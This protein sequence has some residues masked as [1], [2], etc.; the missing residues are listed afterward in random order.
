MYGA[1]VAERFQRERYVKWR[2]DP[3]SIYCIFILLGSVYLAIFFSVY[4]YLQRV[5]LPLYVNDCLE[6]FPNFPLVTS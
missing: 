5:F 1:K 3:L 4:Y 6:L 2:S